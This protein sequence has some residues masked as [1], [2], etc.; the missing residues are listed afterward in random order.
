[1]CS[2]AVSSSA[3]SSSRDRTPACSVN[4]RLCATSSVTSGFAPLPVPEVEQMLRPDTEQALRNA[5]YSI[6]MSALVWTACG[7]MLWGSITGSCLG[8]LPGWDHR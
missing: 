5:T 7:G 2:R 4:V 6:T 8:G 3:I 1:M